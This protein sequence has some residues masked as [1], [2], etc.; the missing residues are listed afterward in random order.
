MWDGRGVKF[1]SSI[2]FEI[3]E[4]K[5]DKK[6]YLRG[7]YNGKIFQFVNINK[8]EIILFDEFENFVNELQPTDEECL[9]GCIL[10]LLFIIFILI[11][12]FIL[13]YSLFYVL[14]LF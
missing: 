13:F 6:L 5:S 7:A 12:F 11:L 2:I 14:I 3:L 1:A 9:Y 8:Q 4:R 10:L